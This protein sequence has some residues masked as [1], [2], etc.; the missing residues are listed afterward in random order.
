MDINKILSKKLLLGLFG[1]IILAELI[2][3]GVYVF[4]MNNQSDSAPQ[5]SSPIITK[6][7]LTSDKNQVKIGE[8]FTVSI[9]IVSDYLTDGV[10]LIINFDP[11]LLSVET[12]G[13]DKAPVVLGALYQDFPVNK[14]EAGKI[15]VSG[16]TDGEGVLANGLFGSVI[17]KT[18]K[19]GQTSV[20]L[21]FQKDNT[22]D[23]NVIEKGTGKDILMDVKNVNITILP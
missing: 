23:T 5:A 21:D 17:F 2:W 3:A 15:T 20:G 6:V 8:E 16:I 12:A 19:A 11:E 9:N 10:D 13:E 22:T 14:I 18:K 7:E 1:L 4:N